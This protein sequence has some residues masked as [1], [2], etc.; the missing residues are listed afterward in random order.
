MKKI[1][2]YS[3]LNMNKKL[4]LQV[5]EWGQ[6]LKSRPKKRT[7]LETLP[8]VKISDNSAFIELFS[9]TIATVPQ[10]SI[11]KVPLSLH[12]CEHVV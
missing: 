8:H 5:S 4:N 7:F 3:S 11:T 12:C 6:I 1:P 9:V 10:D 2:S